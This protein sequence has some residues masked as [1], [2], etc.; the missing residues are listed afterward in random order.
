MIE[1]MGVGAVQNREAHGCADRAP[2]DGFTAC[3]ARP[4]RPSALDATHRQLSNHPTASNKKGTTRQRRPPISSPR[5]AGDAIPV[6]WDQLA[7][8]PPPPWPRPRPPPVLA[9]PPRRWP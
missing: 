1:R 2:M 7:R 4:L 5:A 6:S 9:P 8:P 3:F